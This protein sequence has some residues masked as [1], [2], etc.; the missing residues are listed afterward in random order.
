MM[1][2]S[3]IFPCMFAEANIS[4]FSCRQ[5]HRTEQEQVL[6]ALLYVEGDSRPT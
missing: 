1:I 4:I 6:D 5:L 2:R 3:A